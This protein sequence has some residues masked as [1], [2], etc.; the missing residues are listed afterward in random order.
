MK[1]AAEWRNFGEV[2]ARKKEGETDDDDD[3]DDEGSELLGG[4][5]ILVDT[6]PMVDDTERIEIA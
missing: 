4:G 5:E 2:L 1:K 3:N 6:V